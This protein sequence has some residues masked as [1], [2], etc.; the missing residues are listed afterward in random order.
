MNL[1]VCC[2]SAYQKTLF[3]YSI[4]I[5]LLLRICCIVES[6]HT[7]GIKV[8]RLKVLG[9]FASRLFAFFNAKQIG[10]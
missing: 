7:D 8:L 2:D 3:N 4:L 9:I 10:V 1:V 5:V 6:I